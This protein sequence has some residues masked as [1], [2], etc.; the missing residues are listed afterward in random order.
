[1]PVV[2][3]PVCME[4]GVPYEI[5]G[6]T[7]N[8]CL[9]PHKQT[10]TCLIARLKCSHAL[11]R[12][13]I[14]TSRREVLSSWKHTELIYQVHKHQYE[15]ECR[16]LKTYQANLPLNGV[17]VIRVGMN[18]RLNVFMAVEFPILGAVC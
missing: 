18:H 11:I 13:Y 5:M 15:N 9:L 14:W 4:R 8:I 12:G 1:M 7:S 2:S 17:N 10:N 3:S 16:V 6:K